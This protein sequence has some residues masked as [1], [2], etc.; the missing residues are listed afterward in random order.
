MEGRWLQV[1]PQLSHLVLED[2][3][4]R[5]QSN[6][7]WVEKR[8]ST[9]V[10]SVTRLQLIGLVR[11]ALLFTMQFPALD[12]L[13]LECNQEGIYCFGSIAHKQCART[14][15]T[16]VL[17]GNP[18]RSRNT[19]WSLEKVAKFIAPLK[20][21]TTILIGESLWNKIRSQIGETLTPTIT[22]LDGK[23]VYQVGASDF[24]GELENF[25][26]RQ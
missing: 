8:R 13:Q 19:N 16:L 17:Q 20:E 3:K 2:N 4:S 7:L 12:L 24:T 1:F 5:P 15:K 9:A 23:K 21:L 11:D 10:P 6:W 14:A 18:F 26:K 25:L 22:T